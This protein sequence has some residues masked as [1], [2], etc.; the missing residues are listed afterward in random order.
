MDTAQAFTVALVILVGA[1]LVFGMGYFGGRLLGYRLGLEK[2][3]TL[4]GR[5]EHLKGMSD[6]YVMSL[7]HTP[8]QRDEYMNNVLLRT[9]AITAQQLQDERQRRFRM[10]M[11]A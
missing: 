5:V 3:K 2:G 11:E 4:S 7:H 9:G 10:R 1:I 8:A 6:G